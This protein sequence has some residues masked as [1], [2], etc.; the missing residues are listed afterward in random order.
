MQAFCLFRPEKPGTLDQVRVLY[1]CLGVLC[2]KSQNP[3]TKSQINLKFQYSMTKTFSDETLF[4]FSNFGH[5]KLVDICHL[6][7]G[8]STNQ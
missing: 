4:G 6:T 7:F 3:S 2:L 1:L 5:W 8:I